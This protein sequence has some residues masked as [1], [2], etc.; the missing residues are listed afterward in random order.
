MFRRVQKR[1]R[2]SS[3][4]EPP[5]EERAAERDLARRFL[6]MELLELLGVQGDFL[7]YQDILMRQ[8]ELWTVIFHADVA[9]FSE[10]V[11]E[12]QTSEAYLYINEMLSCSIPRINDNGGIIDTI[13]GAGVV[14]LFADCMRGG[15]DAAIAVCEAVKDRRYSVGLCYGPVIVGVVGSGSRLA[16][17]TLS[18]YTGLGSFLQ[19]LGPKY[20]ARI[21]AVGSYTDRVEDFERKYNHRMLGYIYIKNANRAEKI[22]DI[23]DG[24]EAAV[25]NRK[26]RTKML[27]EKGVLFFTRREFAEART[28]FIEVLK[29]DRDDRA[30]REYVFLCDRCSDMAAG[31][32]SPDIYL[33]CY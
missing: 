13:H 26:R 24:D 17:Q 12:M 3:N 32:P 22:F 20:Y 15:I 25:R 28:Y 8:Q 23:F 6:P 16:V 30:A 14:A 29:A 2:E 21:L 31:E 33:E 9:G 18:A 7:T 11:R 5:Y 19:Q 1:E 10:F 4:G 27:F